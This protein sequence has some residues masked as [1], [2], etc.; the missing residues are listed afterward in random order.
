MLELVQLQLTLC[1]VVVTE[2]GVTVVSVGTQDAA[3]DQHGSARQ[4]AVLLLFLH[5]WNHYVLWLDSGSTS[6]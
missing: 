3:T 5:H 4:T 6:A 2:P 1:P